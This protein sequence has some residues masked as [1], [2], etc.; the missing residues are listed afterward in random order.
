MENHYQNIWTR[1]GFSDNP[2]DTKALSRSGILPIEQAYIKRNDYGEI[3]GILDSFFANPGGGNIIIEGDS[4][5]GKT[6]FV[7]YH[8]FLWK[9]RDKGIRLFSPDTEISVQSTWEIKN[10]IYN[11]LGV[12]LSQIRLDIGERKFNR[13]RILKEILSQT[14]YW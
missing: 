3:G 7:N 10:F 12:L 9:S 2:Y 4:G 14:G 1:F 8:K 5:V 11:A 13:S 6:T